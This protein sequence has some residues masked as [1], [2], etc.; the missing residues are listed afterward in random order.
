MD[1]TLRY[2]AENAQ[3]FAADTAAV[4]FSQ[5]QERFDAINAQYLSDDPA[6]FFPDPLL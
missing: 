6:P 4:D 5:T 2:Y 1:K 3:K